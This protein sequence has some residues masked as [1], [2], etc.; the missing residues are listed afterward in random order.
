MRYPNILLN[1][2][3]SYKLPNHTLCQYITEL[4]PILIHYQAIPYLNTLPNH[5][6][7]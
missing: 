3:L 1:Y 2:R 6:L 7:F 4:D 5:T